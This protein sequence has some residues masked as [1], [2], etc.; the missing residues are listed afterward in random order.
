MEISE[1]TRQWIP[2][3]LVLVFEI[4]TVILLMN[5]MVSHIHLI[6]YHKL[7]I[8]YIISIQFIAYAFKHLPVYLHIFLVT[9]SNCS[10]II[11]TIAYMQVISV[12]P[13]SYHF[14]FLRF[15]LIE[16][17]RISLMHL[18]RLF[19]VEP[20]LSRDKETRQDTD[21][22]YQLFFHEPGIRLRMQPLK[23]PRK[24]HE[25]IFQMDNWHRLG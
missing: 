17:P 14:D 1:G 25:E 16:N 7:I 13:L 24:V 15:P 8:V 4:I 18:I 23:G 11:D 5:L 12:E 6:N 19:S 21:K 20:L 3:I 22:A 2:S 10:N 9:K